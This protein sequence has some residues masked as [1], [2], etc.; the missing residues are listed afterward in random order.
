VVNQIYGLLK[1]E[2]Y[3]SMTSKC[4]EPI[5]NSMIIR[6]CLTI[7]SLYFL[8]TKLHIDFLNNNLLLILPILLTLLDFT[9]NIETFELKYRKKENGC[10]K[11]FDYQIKDKILDISSYFYT[12][13]LFPLDRNIGLLSLYRTI[14]TILFSIT[15]K[16][17]WLVVF[18]DFVKEYMVYIYFFK[19]NFKYLPLTT[20]IKIAF[21]FYFHSEINKENY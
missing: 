11:T 3:I 17:Y 21:E 18:F 12:Y 6:G 8:S 9:D 14:G 10:T 19:D 13:Y 2:Q 1:I 7:L 4:S 5:N 16:S 15:K 20:L